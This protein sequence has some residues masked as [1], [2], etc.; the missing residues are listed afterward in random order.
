MGEDSKGGE[1]I[2]KVMARA[3]VA[4]RRDAERLIVAGRVAVNGQ[5]VTSPARDVL[6]SDR[7]TLDGRPIDAPQPTRLWLYYKPLGLVTS[8]KDEKGRQTVFE[9]LPEGMPRVMSIGRLDLNSEGLLLLT[10]NGELKRRLELPATGWLRKYR[11]RVNGTP[12]DATFD[13][14]RRGLTIDG[15]DFLPMEVTLDR[16]KGANAWLTVGL[17]EGRNREVRRAMAEVGLVVNR[18]IRVS[19]G[20]FRLNEMKP[21]DVIEVKARVMRD[22]LGGLLDGLAP[23]GTGGAEA[24]TGAGTGPAGRPARPRKPRQGAA[25]GSRERRP[26]TAGHGAGPAPGGDGGGRPPRKPGKDAAAARRK[27][28]PPERPAG[29]KPPARRQAPGPDGEAPHRR[30][31]PRVD[32]AKGGKAPRETPP[33]RQGP[34]RP[35]TGAATPAG[36][37]RAARGPQGR[38]PDS[39]PRRGTSAPRGPHGKAKPAGAGADARKAGGKTGG[40]GGWARDRAQ[41]G[42]AGPAR[43]GDERPRPASAGPRPRGKGGAGPAGP[44]R[45]RGGPGKR[46]P[47]R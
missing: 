11:V 23:A 2:A 25:P 39:P 27:G 16:Q 35:G 4:S 29:G 1:R 41:D 32:A 6:P 20:P 46:R 18:L 22:Q 12:T 24:G 34:R 30:R 38:G 33:A 19:Y 10:N 40:R 43:H 45:P 14:L 13:P 28:P 47:G 5:T 44:T 9:S 15:E 7:V 31:A 3:G 42:V 8:E 36:T 17:R 37:P 21:G 26:G